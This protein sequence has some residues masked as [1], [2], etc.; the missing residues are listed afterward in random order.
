M[1]CRAAAGLT[2]DSRI[3]SMMRSAVSSPIT[4]RSI[5]I[6]WSGSCGSSFSLTLG[7]S[8]PLAQV[9]L[10]DVEYGA[11]V[12]RGLIPGTVSVRPPRE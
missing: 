2:P 7:T 5:S 8:H 4:A 6:H 3:C 11:A 10:F 9:Y 12:R 1:P